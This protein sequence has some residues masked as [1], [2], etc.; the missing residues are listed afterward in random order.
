MSRT[1]KVTLLSAT[2]ALAAASLLTAVSPADAA[3][4]TGGDGSPV[5]ARS[6]V[7]AASAVGGSIV[8]IHA[9][10][11]WLSRPDG[12]GQRAVTKD[13]TATTPYEHPTM[14]DAGIIAVM[15]GETIVRMRQ[16]G[17]VLNRITPEDLFVP[18]YGT[19]TISPILDPEISPDGSKIAYSQLRLERYNGPGGYLETEAET[20]FTDAA[21]W[22]GPD[23]YGIQLGYQPSWVTNSRVTLNRSGDVHLA[24]LGHP[25]TPWFYS[26]DIFGQFIELQ[27]TEVSPD[28]NRVIFGSAGGI[29]MKTTVGDPRTGTPGKPTANPECYLTPDA[30]Q[31]VAKDPSFGPDSDSAAYSEG[32]DLWVITGLAACGPTTTVTKIATGGTEPSWSPAPLSAAPAPGPQAFAL[33]KAP[34]VSG[35][36]KVGKR[37]RASTGTWSPAPSGVSYTWLRNGKV[38]RGRTASTYV[39]GRADRGKRIQVRV[40]VRRNGY[41]TRS[42]VSSTVTVRR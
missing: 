12:S 16:D 30:G 32:G 36:A 13:G 17:V 10:N 6:S 5:R 31:P 42:A 25:S 26:N 24:D 11:V 14:S 22:A 9:D 2:T 18:D 15:K 28:G 3:S 1:R 20:G 35:K 19:V 8:Y 38:V 37:L 41:T 21:Q 29:G 27:E 33:A 34:V 40:T 39:V 4:I 7:A 23:K